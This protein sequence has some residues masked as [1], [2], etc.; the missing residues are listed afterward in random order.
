[1]LPADKWRELKETWRQWLASS[2][3]SV[4]EERQQSSETL[5][6]QENT[7]NS[8]SLCVSLC[9]YVCTVSLLKCLH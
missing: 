2:T 6:A 9:V 8:V 7:I 4:P 1:M 5:A 3:G